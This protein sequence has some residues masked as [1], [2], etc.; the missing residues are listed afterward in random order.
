MYNAFSSSAEISIALPDY[1]YRAEKNGIVENEIC[2]VLLGY[3]NE[4]PKPNPDEVDLIFTVSLQ[5][6]LSNK[7]ST[8]FSLAFGKQRAGL[9][10]VG[11]VCRFVPAAFGFTASLT[12]TFSN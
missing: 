7:Q 10:C 3:T 8:R 12:T 11:G 5:W 2:P 1:R 4:I 9:F 6:L